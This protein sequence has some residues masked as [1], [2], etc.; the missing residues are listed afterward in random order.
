MSRWR[1]DATSVKRQSANFQPRNMIV[2]VIVLILMVMFVTR[3]VQS[4]LLGHL[5]ILAISMAIIGI[6]SIGQTLV[7]ITGGI[8]LSV[9]SVMALTAVMTAYLATNGLGTGFPSFN[10]WIAAAIA[11]LT[12]TGIGYLHG[13]LI[14]RFQLAPFIVTFASLSLVR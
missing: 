2:F 14:A 13:L 12:A 7:V 5:Q 6:V 10:P 3:A 9:G 4:N 1:L 8:D 11:L